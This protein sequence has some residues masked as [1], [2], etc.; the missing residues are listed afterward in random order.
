MVDSRCLVEEVELD[1]SPGRKFQC[2]VLGHFQSSLHHAS[3]LPHGSFF[4]LPVFR[5]FSFR[6]IEISISLAHHYVLG[7]APDGFHV[8]EEL[9][10][11]FL[12]LSCFERCGF[13][14]S[15]SEKSHHRVL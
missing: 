11:H 5:R 7:G 15:F 8:V 1:L 13:C 2:Y 4:L 14:G 9:Y 12:L 3:S 10:R 6:L